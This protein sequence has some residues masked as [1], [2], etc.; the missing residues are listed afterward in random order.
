MKNGL[1]KSPYRSVSK[2]GRAK[3]TPCAEHSEGLPTIKI[4][5]IAAC[6]APLAAA[7][8]LLVAPTKD[9]SGQPPSHSKGSQSRRKPWVAASKLR[10]SHHLRKYLPFTWASMKFKSWKLRVFVNLLSLYDAAK[11]VSLCAGW[12]GKST[13]ITQTQKLPVCIKQLLHLVVLSAWE[14]FQ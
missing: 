8:R 6:G 2:K 1:G 12:K 9:S 4:I 10:N 7:R 14:F 5:K 3:R 11:Q 13:A